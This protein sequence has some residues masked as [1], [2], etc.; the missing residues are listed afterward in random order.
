MISY[1]GLVRCRAMRD[2][3]ALAFVCMLIAACATTGGGGDD[4][5]DPPTGPTCGDAV[6][7]ASEIGV[8]AADCG[9]GMP[10]NEVC[11]NSI[12]E[13]T[14]PSTCATDCAAVCGN[15]TCE[16]TETS[17][18]CPGDCTTGGGGGN[19][20]ADPLECLPCLLDPLFCPSGHTDVTCQACIVGGGGGIPMCSG[21]APNG[22]CDAGE[23]MQTCPLDCP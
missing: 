21:G 20:P 15:N 8:C 10:S 5:V 12:C 16:S 4:G 3:K 14:E 22:V 9:S 2:I 23:T 19:C 18:T 7:A 6:C 1:S 13:G 17:S 11:G